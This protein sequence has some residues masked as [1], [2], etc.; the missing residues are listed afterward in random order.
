MVAEQFNPIAVYLIVAWRVLMICRF[1]RSMPETSCE[2]IFDASEW[3][4]TYRIMHPKKKLPQKP[5]NLH[6]MI[7][8]IGELGGWVSTPGKKEMPQPQTI[9]IGLQR[10]HDFARAWKMF[11]P[12]EEK[13][14]KDV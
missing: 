13:H 2:L 5:P 10:V 12:S 11:G 1:G 7:K 9:W 14:Q 4:S 6:E 8:M 3:K